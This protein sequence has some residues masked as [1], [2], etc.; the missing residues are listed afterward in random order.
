MITCCTFISNEQ[1][2]YLCTMFSEMKCQKLVDS[3]KDNID[4]ILNEMCMK[5]FLYY[6][7]GNKIVGA[8]LIQF[9]N[10]EE[11]FVRL[12]YVDKEYRKQGIFKSFIDFIWNNEDLITPYKR[13][14]EIQLISFGVM[15]HNDTMKT[16]LLKMDRAVNYSNYIYLFRTEEQYNES[17][18]ESA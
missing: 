12:V 11:A 7:V 18:A 9:H 3:S 2:E 5:S 15:G 16:A 17:R 10:T 13:D 1:R 6:T 14:K 4:D 8:C